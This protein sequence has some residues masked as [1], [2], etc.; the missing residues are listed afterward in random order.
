MPAQDPDVV[1]P[2]RDFLHRRVADGLLE[3]AVRRQAG[4]H[5][6]VGT[7]Q[8]A[9]QGTGCVDQA[10]L[11][12]LVEGTAPLV[13]LQTFVLFRSHGHAEVGQFGLA[14]FGQ[15]LGQVVPLVTGKV[16]EP[17]TA[18]TAGSAGVGVGGLGL[19]GSGEDL[20]EAPVELTDV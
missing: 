5:R 11:A 8:S 2:Q 15:N 10:A 3:D 16:E 18:V 20:I 17:A 13:E 6:K 7:G 1:L 14:A 4:L 9:G 12:G 19:I